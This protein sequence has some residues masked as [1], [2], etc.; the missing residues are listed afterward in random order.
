MSAKARVR[1]AAASVALLVS[2]SAAAG[3]PLICRQ[4]D[5]GAARS[6]PWKGSSGWQGADPSYDHSR[7]AG[8]TLALLA[9]ATPIKVRMET[10][11]RAAIYSASKTGAAEALTA[12]LMARTLDAEAR[13]QPDALAW[14]DAGYFV[15]SLRQATFVY[16]HDML[17]P[18]ERAAW[19]LRGEKPPLDGHAWVKRAIKLGGQ[20]MHYALSL[21]EEYRNADL[22]RNAPKLVSAR[23]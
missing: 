12:R 10:M 3:P 7:L 9:P 15:E 22:K 18:A 21:I 5:I 11:R 6:L 13:R 20:D 2:T 8:D 16:R 1:I 4:F 19:K 14:F 23:D 17:S